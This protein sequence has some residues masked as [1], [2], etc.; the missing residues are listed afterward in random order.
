MSMIDQTSNHTNGTGTAPAAKRKIA[1][2]TVSG[3]TISVQFSEHF[4][5]HLLTLDTSTLSPE[6]Q[7]MLA[8]QGAA[9]VIQGA[10]TSPGADPIKAANDM[11]AR[12][13]A[14][15]WHPGPARGEALPDPL[16]QATA[17]YL[18]KQT[19]QDYPYDR[20]EEK[21]LPAY[22]VRHGLGSIGAARRKLRMHPDI[23]P[24]I[25]Q[26][27]SERSKAAALRAKGGHRENLLDLDA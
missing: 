8:A 9:G 22:Q 12:L 23:A 15:T 24:R 18:A 16:V 10:Y 25:A 1:N 27:E 19:G 26:I 14:G 4:G 20:V 6:M 5:K 13:K 21:F 2:S 3:S 11:V 7:A 17:E